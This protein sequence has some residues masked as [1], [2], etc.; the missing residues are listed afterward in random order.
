MTASLEFFALAVLGTSR[1][2]D[3]VSAR[4]ARSML[5]DHHLGTNLLIALAPFVVTLVVI[6]LVVRAVQ[7]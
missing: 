5:V 7:R 3:C 2:P 1:C 4:E 6:L